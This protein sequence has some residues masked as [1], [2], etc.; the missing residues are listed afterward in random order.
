MIGIP[1]D[2]YYDSLESGTQSCLVIVLRSERRIAD[3]RKC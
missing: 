1:A 2:A 3:D